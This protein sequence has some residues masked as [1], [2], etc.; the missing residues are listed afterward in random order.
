MVAVTRMGVTATLCDVNTGDGM[1]VNPSVR[2]Y[3]G[4][5]E[6]EQQVRSRLYPLPGNPARV[7]V[8]PLRS[9]L[10]PVPLPVV[11]T[12]GCRSP[13][14]TQPGGFCPPHTIQT[15]GQRGN[16]EGEETIAVSERDRLNL[17]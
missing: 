14:P 1:S 16:F 17:P 5:G 10:L 8:T 12:G 15:G 7:V 6:A 13:Y 9:G 3:V 11:P 4:L 2:W